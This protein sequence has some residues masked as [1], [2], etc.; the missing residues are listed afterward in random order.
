MQKT[1]INLLFIATIFAFF[2]VVFG[3]FGAHALKGILGEAGLHQYDLG[4]RYAFIHALAIFAAGL[5]MPLAGK[6]KY[7]N[8][9][10]WFFIAGIILFSGNLILLAL[11]QNAA[12]AM[13]IP[14]GGLAFLLGWVFFA[15]GLRGGK[16]HE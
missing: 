7:L 11:S 12:F 16:Q 9:A 15:Y 5:S 2:A 13:I 10:A 6:P 14:L 8:L 3:A 4:V 1:Q